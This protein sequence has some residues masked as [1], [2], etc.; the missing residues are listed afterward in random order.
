[1]RTKGCGALRFTSESRKAALHPQWPRKDAYDI[2]MK[3]QITFASVEEERRRK[4]TAERVGGKCQ[5]RRKASGT[6][7][8]C[9]RA[10]SGSVA[11]RSLNAPAVGHVNLRS[12]A[13]G[14]GE[15][16]AIAE[17]QHKGRV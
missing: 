4:V 11:R 2:L 7:D 16:R 9:L 14:I 8:G 12:L 10:T 5:R 6:K 1:M 13:T 15:S 3:M 17:R